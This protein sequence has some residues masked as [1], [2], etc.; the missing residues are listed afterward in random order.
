MKTC[1][2]K[3]V[4]ERLKASLESGEVKPETIAN[5]LPEEKLALR[6]ILESVVSKELGVKV[7]SEEIAEITKLSKKIDAAQTKLG[8]EIGN[9][10]KVEE[11]VDFFKAKK[12]MDDYLLSRTPSNTLKVATGTIGRGMMLFSVKSPILNIGSNIELGFTDALS[13]RIA[14]FNLKGT[15]N[16]LATDFVKMTN[17]IYQ[18]SGY[19]ISRMTTLSDSG[20]GGS[21]VLGETV[22]SQGKGAV[23]W[24]G[25][26]ISEDI[27]FKQL[28]GA[29]DVVFSAAHF[30]DSVN[31][32]AQK[33]AKPSGK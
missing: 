31:L 2:P 4:V 6:A 25:R 21:R 13:R 9:P 17:K 27:V 29:P 5:M 3:E 16:K 33:L 10:T 23:R 11:N 26:K 28:M 22:H 30:A 32:N 15:D 14:S 7:S 20:A 19:D 24:V 18:T 12:E 8:G 1:I